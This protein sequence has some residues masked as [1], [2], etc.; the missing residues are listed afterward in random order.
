MMKPPASPNNALLSEFKVSAPL[1]NYSGNQNPRS[2]IF[3]CV[4]L[5]WT[6]Y[7]Q[8]M[9]LVPPVGIIL[10]Y[11]PH[12]FGLIHASIRLQTPPQELVRPL[13]VLLGG[14]IFVS[15]ASHIWNDLIDANL[16]AK[17][18]RTSRRPIPRGAVSPFAAV[19]FMATQV[20]IA[21]VFLQLMESPGA[22]AVA[23]ANTI[24]ITYY[25]F[26]KRHIHF[27]QFVLGLCMALAVLMGE[28]AVDKALLSLTETLRTE[29]SFESGVSIVSLMSAALLWTVIYDTVYAHQDFDQDTAAGI[30]G[31]AI[32][33]GRRGTKPVLWILL[34]SV[35]VLLA[36]CGYFSGYGLLFYLVALGGTFTSLA[37]MIARVELSHIESCWWWF[38]KGFWY[39]GGSIIVGL[40][41]E[42][43]SRI[44]V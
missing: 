1:N 23:A 6:E 17:V 27:P 36:T 15:N 5:S 18:A 2:G 19:A 38:S 16:D 8:L 25:P 11:L 21:A 3:A 26:G 32:L 10:I 22:F 9:R 34:L 28:L 39:P 30:K 43:V 13:A 41:V 20:L 14:S 44:L 31:F 42:Y 29:E 12:V 7:I 37:M 24:S 33:C 40:S 35:A 4:P